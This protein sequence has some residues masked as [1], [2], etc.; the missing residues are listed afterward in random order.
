MWRETS[1][2]SWNSTKP[3]RNGVSCKVSLGLETGLAKSPSGGGRA[4]FDYGPWQ[5]GLPDQGWRLHHFYSCGR[6]SHVDSMGSTLNKILGK[7]LCCLTPHSPPSTVCTAHPERDG[8]GQEPDPRGPG[9]TG[10]GHGKF[11]RV[12]GGKTGLPTVLGV[13]KPRLCNTVLGLPLRWGI[14]CLEGEGAVPPPELPPCLLWPLMLPMVP[15]STG[16]QEGC[17]GL[18]H[19]GGT[20]IYS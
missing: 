2:G 17:L 1:V 3:R 19:K 10:I 13:F 15:A 11:P 12:H 16:P 18:G 7:T 8:T 5:A 14:S 9:L 20:A 4:G 6:C